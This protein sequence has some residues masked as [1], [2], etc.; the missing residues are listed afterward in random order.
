PGMCAGSRSPLLDGPCRHATTTSGAEGGTARAPRRSG[1]V[2]AGARVVVG[3]RL[4][5]GGDLVGPRQDHFYQLLRALIIHILSDHLEVLLPDRERLLDLL[6][7]VVLDLFEQVEPLFGLFRGRHPRD[8]RGEH[9]RRD[10]AVVGEGVAV[11]AA[12]TAAGAQGEREGGDEQGGGTEATHEET[13]EG[14][15]GRGP[16]PAARRTCVSGPPV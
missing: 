10:G 15:G 1:S 9:R 14:C 4:T 5:G 13:P 11:G 16:P 2:Q 7:H 8:G 6:G 12:P 3:Q